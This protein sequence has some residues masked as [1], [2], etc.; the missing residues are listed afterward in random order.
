MTRY[1][2]RT[3]NRDRQR[4]HV[5]TAESSDLDPRGDHVGMTAA[6]R[7]QL[8]TEALERLQRHDPNH[9]HT[10]EMLSAD[11]ASLT[12]TM[13][14]AGWNLNECQRRGIKPQFRSEDPELIAGILDRAEIQLLDLDREN[15]LWNPE[16]GRLVITD[17]DSIVLRDQPLTTAQQRRLEQLAGGTETLQLITWIQQQLETPE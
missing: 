10:P 13:R 16:T 12:I 17:F 11:P 9:W 6:E 5:K 2:D 3:V 15:L 8:E 7:W 1:L 4:W 14:W